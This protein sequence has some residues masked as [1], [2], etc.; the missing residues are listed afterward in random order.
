VTIT[1][2]GQSI[3]PTSSLNYIHAVSFGQMTLSGGGLTGAAQMAR[4]NAGTNPSNLFGTLFAANYQFSAGGGGS[5]DAST[6]VPLDGYDQPGVTTSTPYTVYV[7]N[8]SAS[9]TMTW[10]D[11][12]NATQNIGTIRLEEIMGSLEPANDNAPL[13]MVG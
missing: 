5:G 10:L 13:S 6:S 2:L 7:W 9:S 1:S 3:T 4:S 8:P 12:P 11:N